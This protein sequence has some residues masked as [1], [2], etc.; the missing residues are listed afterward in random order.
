MWPFGKNQR[1]GTGRRRRT[2]GAP[3][4][5]PVTYRGWAEK[6][7]NVRPEWRA[8]PKFNDLMAAH[9]RVQRAQPFNYGG[10]AFDHATVGETPDPRGSEQPVEVLLWQLTQ[11]YSDLGHLQYDLRSSGV[12]LWFP[13]RLPTFGVYP[14]SPHWKPRMKDF[15]AYTEY[16]LFEGDAEV[17][18]LRF[19]GTKVVAA[20][21]GSVA[22]LMTPEVLG[23]PQLGG[24]HWRLDGN[25]AVAWSKGHKSPDMLAEAVVDICAMVAGIPQELLD[26]AAGPAQGPQGLSG[27]SGPDRP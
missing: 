11:H 10:Y 16:L 21:A 5:P 27:G 23:L 1:R 9:K 3:P 18:G 13:Y 12:V 20:D 2:D 8:L 26:L 7:D 22:A 19:A 25:T 14:E 17:A 15:S 4:P 24:R 6:W